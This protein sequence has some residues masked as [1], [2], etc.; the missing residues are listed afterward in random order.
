MP[1]RIDAILVS[2]VRTAYDEAGRPVGD[3]VSQPVKLYLAA[4]PDLERAFL[5]AI[6][7]H[8]SSSTPSDEGRRDD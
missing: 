1:D 4:F 8:E 6:E 3:Q 2:A 7:P 5:A